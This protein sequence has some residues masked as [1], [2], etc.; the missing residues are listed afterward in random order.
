M[1]G[2]VYEIVT[3]KIIEQL[4]AGTVPWHK[5]WVGG[6]AINYVSRKPYQGIN[7]LLLPFGGE[8]LTFNQAKAAGG[9]IRKGEKSSMIVF[10][11]MLEKKDEGR[12][13][14]VNAEYLPFLR[15]TNVFHI[16]QCDG[17]ESKLEQTERDEVAPI[18]SAQAIIDEYLSRSGV[19]FSH[20]EGGNMACYNMNHDRITMPPMNRFDSIEAYYSV[21]F[22]EA[23]HSTG[24]PSRLNREGLGEVA[25]GSKVYGREELIAEICS[26]FVLDIAGIDPA[27]TLENT[28]AYIQAWMKTIKEDTRAIVTAASK[29]QKAANLILGVELQTE[30]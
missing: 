8:W 9:S 14:S 2:K 17:I 20:I 16:S 18:E 29:A 21:S 13:E 24:H 5:P 12:Q 6:E 25:F 11:K 28:T 23:A 4:E 3:Q 30:G 26:A 15:Y 10:F 19:N 7:R 27:V 22:H 1:T